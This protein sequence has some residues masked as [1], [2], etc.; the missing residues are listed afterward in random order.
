MEYGIER[1]E[2]GVPRSSKALPH[3]APLP[4][5]GMKIGEISTPKPSA[6]SA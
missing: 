5:P 6:I 4:N 3:K 1:Q 2:V